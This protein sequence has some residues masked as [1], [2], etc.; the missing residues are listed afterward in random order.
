MAEGHNPM[1]VGM[2]AL[3]AGNS[4]GMQQVLLLGSRSNAPGSFG[5]FTDPKF[6]NNFSM[7]HSM[8]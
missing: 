2:L 6:P 3:V 8:T 5:S 7:H 4:C 1:Y